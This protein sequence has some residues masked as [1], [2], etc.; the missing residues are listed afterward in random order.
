MVHT[1][2]T[3]I[4]GN[5]NALYIHDNQS[6][7]PVA[8]IGNNGSGAS[9]YVEQQGSGET[10]IFQGNGVMIQGTRG[11]QNALTIRDQQTNYPTAWIANNGSGNTLHVQQEGT[12]LT[13]NFF[14]KQGV[15]ISGAR[16]NQNAL[17]ITDNQTSYP[18]L[19]IA[20]NGSGATLNAK[21]EG[22]GPIAKFQGQTDKA[23]FVITGKINPESI[24]IKIIQAEKPV[25][26]P[27]RNFADLSLAEN[28]TPIGKALDKV[29]S[30]QGVSFSWKDK[31]LGTD[32]QIGISAQEVQKVF[33]EL[34]HS[35][36]GQSLL[37]KYEKFV[38]V[39]I[40]AIKEQQVQ[41]KVLQQEVAA[42]KTQ[43]SSQANQ[44]NGGKESEKFVPDF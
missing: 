21:Q 34:L 37:V 43:V 4:S 7:Y 44:E 31:T 1:E 9:L 10:A 30:L 26:I 40:E 27:S 11:D 39:L 12:G 16:G 42:L 20:N 35:G 29:S 2:I 36:D 19:W 28:I 5:N 23:S 6:N 25:W 18:T 14:G 38:P 33:P 17:K 15:N 3:G 22:S 41:I 24:G 13:A 32:K 8:W